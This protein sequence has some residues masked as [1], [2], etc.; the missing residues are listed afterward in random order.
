M[1]DLQFEILDQL[2]FVISYE[3]LRKQLGIE[4]IVLNAEL[5]RLHSI[6]F[7]RVFESPD[8]TMDFEEFDDHLLM[9]SYLL[10]SKKGLKAHNSQ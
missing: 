5:H 2:Y 10:A 3:E 9:N 8:K 6:D 4:S 1:T 7:V